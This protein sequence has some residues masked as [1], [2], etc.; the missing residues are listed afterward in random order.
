MQHMARDGKK[1]FILAKAV[2]A[3][4][5]P[6]GLD[7]ERFQLGLDEL[8]QGYLVLIPVLLRFELF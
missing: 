2:H 7:T 8:L 3:F 6:T 4:M 5:Q 1:R